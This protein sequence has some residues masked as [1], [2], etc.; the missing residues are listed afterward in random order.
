MSAL[1]ENRI[2]AVTGANGYVGGAIRSYL[3]AHH[4]TIIPWTRQGGPSCKPFRLGEKPDPEMFRG[5]SAL[6]HCAYDFKVRKWSEIEGINVAGSEKLFESAR[7][8]GVGSIVF[9]SSI[10]AFTGCRSLYG[11]AKLEIEIIAKSKG[12]TCIR[13]GL[14]YDQ[15][16]GGVFGR[17]VAQVKKSKFVP[18]IS[19]G[20]QTQ[21]LV[22]SSDLGQLVLACIEGKVPH[23]TGPITIAHQKGWEL[24]EILDLIAVR[25][26]KRIVSIPAPWRLV[27]LLLK[28]F[29]AA[30]FHSNFRSD[31]LVGMVYQNPK[32]SFELLSALGFHCRPFEPESLF[33]FPNPDLPVQRK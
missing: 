26:G 7:E 4:W 22:H 28:G 6:V 9:I 21:Y 19:G 33:L 29:E 13:P 16:P 14:V 5:I 10:S 3:E 27:W 11:K 1:G 23:G 8:A 15:N 25:M 18:R 24:K 20:V 30:G 17:L 31:S 12:I 2:C 32:P